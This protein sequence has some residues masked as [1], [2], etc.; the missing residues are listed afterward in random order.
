ML[1]GS[2]MG[3]TKHKPLRAR[4]SLWLSALTFGKHFF[5]NKAW[6]RTLPCKSNTKI[7]KFV[8]LIKAMQIFWKPFLGCKG[9]GINQLRKYTTALCKYDA[10]ASC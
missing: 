5:E 1:F 6:N 3:Q 9:C 4:D 2:K 7:L 8:K 10:R